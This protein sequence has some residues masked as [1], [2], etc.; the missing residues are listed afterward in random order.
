MVNV[1]AKEPIM[2]EVE[3]LVIRT[4]LYFA[5]QHGIV[6]LPDLFEMVYWDYHQKEKDKLMEAAI[7]RGDHE[8][9]NMTADEFTKFTYNGVLE[10]PYLEPALQVLEIAQMIHDCMGQHQ[11]FFEDYTGELINSPVCGVW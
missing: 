6:Y 8:L 11:L 1:V 3:N 5:D 4:Y 7:D 10:L 2:N 9:Y